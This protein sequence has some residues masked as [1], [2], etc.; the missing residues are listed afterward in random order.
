MYMLGKKQKHKDGERQ[1]GRWTENRSPAKSTHGS[2][3]LTFSLQEQS[4][5]SRLETPSAV[6]LAVLSSSLPAP[7]HV[8]KPMGR[9]GNPEVSGRRTDQAGGCDGF[10][11]V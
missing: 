11:D 9:K 7:M 3:L 2:A 6:P 10:G 4:W 1:T 5:Y 8:G